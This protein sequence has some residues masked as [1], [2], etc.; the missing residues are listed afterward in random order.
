MD[1]LGLCQFVFGP[2]WQLYGPQDQAELLSAATGWSLAVDDIQRIGKKRLNLMRAL[3]AREGLA[4]DQDTL[5]TKLFRKPLRGGPSDG[6]V[7]EQSELESGLQMYYVQAGWDEETGVPTRE[8][9]DE[10]GLSW[11][12]DDLSR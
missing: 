9:L 7:L 1:T 5:P 6:L 3:N 4:R 8:T 2:A 12:A 10:L 11:A